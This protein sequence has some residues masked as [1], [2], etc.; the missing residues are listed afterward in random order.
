MRHLLFQSVSTFLHYR[1]I[2][3]NICATYNVCSGHRIGTAEVESALV[4]HPKCAEAAVVGVEHEV[5]W[6]TS[7]L[8]IY[9]FFMKAYLC[10]GVVFA[11]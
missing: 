10:C 2:P 5:L 1:H 7:A 8:V 9:A 11:R 3:L 6:R 4:S